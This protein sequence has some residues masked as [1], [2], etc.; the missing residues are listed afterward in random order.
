MEHVAAST[1]G[2]TATAA[3]V[4]AFVSCPLC[5]IPLITFMM[6]GGHVL[7][8]CATC[9]YTQPLCRCRMCEAFFYHQR[10]MA[11]P[12]T[13]SAAAPVAPVAAPMTWSPVTRR[14]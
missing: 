9:R 11:T 8:Y 14:E 10:V 7:G 13:P 5:N 2:M 3:T 4:G 12:P 6:E 1:A